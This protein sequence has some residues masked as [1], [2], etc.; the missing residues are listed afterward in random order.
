MH[1]KWA[2]KAHF[3]LE[4][5]E[6][7]A[8][9]RMKE[10]S[11]TTDVENNLS[12]NSNSSN[13]NLIAKIEK[14]ASEVCVRENCELYDV[15][16]TGTGGGRIV[17]VYVDRFDEN[18]RSIVGIDECANVSRGL[19]LILDVE[20]IIPGGAYDLEVSTPGLDRRLRKPAH[21]QKAIG[22]KVWIQLSQNLGSL[23]AQKAAIQ[24]TKKF[25]DHLKGFADNQLHFELHGEVVKVPVT[26]IEKCK[27][28]FEVIKGQKGPKRK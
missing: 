7:D 10:N 23:G 19:N 15:E 5:T 4:K 16:M 1:K 20:D 21:F 22:K 8:L 12:E 27:V 17:R 28:V 25:E 26:A 9:K 11:N 3:F 2:L 6:S 14:L 18:G 24:A 13:M